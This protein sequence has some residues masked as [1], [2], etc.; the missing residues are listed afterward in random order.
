MSTAK[1]KESMSGGK[2]T[3]VPKGC[4]D[5]PST[6]SRPLCGSAVMDEEGYSANRDVGST[7][8]ASDGSLPETSNPSPVWSKR[9]GHGAPQLC[10]MNTVRS[11]IIHS[12]NTLGLCG[13]LFVPLLPQVTAAQDHCDS[14]AILHVRYHPFSDTLVNVHVQNAGTNFFS[15]PTFHLLSANGD[16]LAVEV[17]EFFGIGNA[18]Q[19]HHLSLVPGVALPASPFT[20]SL[21]LLSYGWE[22]EDTCTY[23]VETDLCPPDSCPPLSVFLYSVAGG[24]QLFTASFNWQVSDSFGTTVASG[25]FG[26]AMEDQQQTFAELCLPPGH[27]ALHVQEPE[28]VGLQYN[29]G[30]CQQGNQ[31]ANVGPSAI[32]VAGQQITVPFHYYAP[33][34]DGSNIISEQ[35]AYA[36]VLV[37]DDR[38]LRI[39]SADGAALG[40]LSV[41][42]AT[43][44]NVLRAQARSASTVLD[45]QGAAAGVYLLCGKGGWPAQ[46]F[47]LR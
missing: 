40:P 11:S 8:R 35:R 23:A 37:L 42:D 24:G 25:T 4:P 30:L 36:P 44:R 20:G 32:L 43:G 15:G 7:R 47:T 38:L 10:T 16:T 46:R 5:R 18:P 28:N 2:S 17:Q 14:L 22:G 1:K 19:T 6:L 39:A 45:L 33:C 12:T 27:Y 3:L 9:N 13:L 29:V 41:V 31:F 21:L 26:I 34:I